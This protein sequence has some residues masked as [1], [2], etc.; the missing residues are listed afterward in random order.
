MITKE[1]LKEKS[2]CDEGVKW[3]LSQK[4]TEGVKVVKDLIKTDKLNWSNWL[5]V[6]LMNHN[7][8]IKYAI[9]TAEQVI[10]IYEKK[11]PHDKRPRKAIEA[12]KKYL[13]NP[14]EKNENAADAAY[15]AAA[16]AAYAATAY[17]AADNAAVDA[18]G[19]EIK[20]KIINYGLELL[21]GAKMKGVC[22]YKAY[23]Y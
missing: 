15:A 22:K 12:A 14:N 2:A 5:I 3:F 11:Y 10:D 23:P 9:F 17:A 1:W 8:Q 20:I 13:E 21:Q 16:A 18:A 4:E 7:Q 19:K 6:Q